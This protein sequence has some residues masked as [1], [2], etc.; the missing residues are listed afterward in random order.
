M[1]CLGN[2]SEDFTLDNMKR[3]KKTGL[4]RAVKVF[5]IDYNPIST[6]NILDIDR[7]NVWNYLKNV[8]T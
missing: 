4:N 7:K 6:S 1:L 3:K 2:I 5:S 8:I